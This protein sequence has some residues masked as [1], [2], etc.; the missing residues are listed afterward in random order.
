MEPDETP[1]W[2][3]P[4]SAPHPY[5]APRRT[6]LKH[7]SLAAIAFLLFIITL[8]LAGAYFS[9]ELD[10]FP[11]GSGSYT[12]V[13][14]PGLLPF[15]QRHEP[16]PGQEEAD[17]PLGRP[18]QESW[19]SDSYEFLAV[20][21][22]GSPLTYSP[23]RPI[24]YVVNQEQA[25]PGGEAILEEAIRRT[26]RAS[27]LQFIFDGTTQEL[28]SDERPG[29]QPGSYGDR[30][31]PVLIAWANPQLVPRLSG[32]TVGLGGSSAIS[33]SNGFKAYVTGTVSLDAPQFEDVL[34]ER[35]GRQV[36]TA[37]IMHELGH[38]LGL[39]HVNDPGQLMYDEASNVRDFEDGDLAGLA[40]L[41]TGPCSKLY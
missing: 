17:A 38:L 10:V 3:R 16:P 15:G 24:H 23:C 18:A 5:T 2:P 28:P 34:A 25:P 20:K 12:P 30:W 8:V 6:G 21:E 13:P 39:D 22:D 32:Q 29:Y 4:Y 27:G 19:I 41:G 11:Q 26:S 37:V 33:L 36:A 1:Q 7:S 31:A 40:I 35:G 9:R 14:R